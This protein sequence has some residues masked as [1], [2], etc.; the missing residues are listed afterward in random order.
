MTHHPFTFSRFF[1]AL[2]LPADNSLTQEGA[3]LGALLFF[4]PRLSLNSSLSCGEC[5]QARAAFTEPRAVSRGAEGQPGTRNAMPLF[6][7][8][9]KSS[10]F[11]DGRAASLRDQVLQAIQGTNEMHETL[12]NV[13]ARIEKS[14]VNPRHQARALASL[15]QRRG[16][17]ANNGEIPQ[18]GEALWSFTGLSSNDFNQASRSLPDP[19]L[20]FTM[21]RPFEAFGHADDYPSLFANVFGTPE[22][23]AERIARALEQFL[24]VQVSCASKFDYVLA[25]KA[26]LTPDEQRGFDFFRTEFNPSSGQRGGDCFRCHGEPLFRNVDFANN[27]LDSDFQD[28][29]RYLVTGQDRDMGKFAVP[30]LRNVAVT[31]PYMHDGRFRSLEE[32]IEHYSTGVKRSATLDPVLARHPAGGLAPGPADKH[33]LIAFLKTLTDERFVVD[34]E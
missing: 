12:E 33:A 16:P 3:R 4:D 20:K 34:P 17:D 21:F 14:R 18:P 28:L 23:S 9:W 2:A 24:L 19:P 5:H 22:I 31:A 29:G 30:S 32:V 13:V 7:L 27:G 8:A 26:K 25:G 15:P 10:F 1:P 6:N 11:W